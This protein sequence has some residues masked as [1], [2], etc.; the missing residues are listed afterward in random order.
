MKAEEDRIGPV[1][2]A[3]ADPTRRR[4]VELL[5]EA[6]HRAGDLAAVLQLPAPAVSKHLRVLLEAGLVADERPRGDARVRVFR[7]RAGSVAGLQAW[8]DQLQAHWDEQLGSFKAHVEGK[9][10]R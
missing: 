10:G 8:L 4:V 2:R 7:L 5:S 3:L 9:A 1:L 6:P